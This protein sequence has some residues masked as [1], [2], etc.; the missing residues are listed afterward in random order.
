[1]KLKNAFVRYSR[2]KFR[3]LN[4]EI[5]KDTLDK[6]RTLLIFTQ[7]ENAD[8]AMIFMDKIRKDAPSEVSWL[9][10][11]KYSFYI[12]SSTNLE[13]LK[14]NKNLVNYLEL[15]NKKYPGKF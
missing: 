7:F 1:M 6:E 4:L 3:L 8:A 13:L 11:D 9:P 10:A 12:I 15:L 2:E 14:L 5:T